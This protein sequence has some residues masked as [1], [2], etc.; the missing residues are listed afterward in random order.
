VFSIVLRVNLP[1]DLLAWNRFMTP[2]LRHFMA[3]IWS[4]GSGRRFVKNYS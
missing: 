2:L 3:D 4:M 1:V